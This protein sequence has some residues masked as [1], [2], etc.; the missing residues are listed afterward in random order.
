MTPQELFGHAGT[1]AMAGWVVLVLAPRRWDA[2]NAVPALLIPAG[3]SALYAALILRHFADAP[4]G[5]GSLADVAALLSGEWMLLAGWV[6]YL[7]FDLAIGA[8]MARRMDGAG[9]SRI[10]QAPILAS[11]FLFGPLGFLLALVASGAMRPPA[12]AHRLG[13]L[14]SSAIPA[15]ERT[16]ALA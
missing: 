6:H 13:A 16:H 5:Y 9:L 4:G 8:V 14:R 11:I 15:T 2:L 1:A 12:F 7:A 10:V 3:L